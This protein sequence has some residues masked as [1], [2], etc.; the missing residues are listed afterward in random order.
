MARQW[1]TERIG[2][3]ATTDEA[4]SEGYRAY[5]ERQAALWGQ[6]GGSFAHMWRNTQH[7]LDVAN[8]D[9]SLPP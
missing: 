8:A 5:A 3:I 9:V 6:I 1:W 7:L 4:L 2:A